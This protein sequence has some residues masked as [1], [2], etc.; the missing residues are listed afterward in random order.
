MMENTRKAFVKQED[1]SFIESRPEDLKKDMI[2]K[3]V[4]PDGT[5]VMG[6]YSDLF[7][8]TTDAFLNEEEVL[9]MGV[10]MLD[11]NGQIVPEDNDTEY[12]DFDELP[13]D[14]EDED[15]EDIE[16]DY[17]DSNDEDCCDCDCCSGDD[18]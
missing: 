7:L 11:A 17:D 8:A 14:D 3:L 9:E 1:G 4:D 6:M 18:D 15:Y 12:W 5:Q 2:F 16:P 10:E 13:D